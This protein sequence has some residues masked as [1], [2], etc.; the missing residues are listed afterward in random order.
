MQNG[1]PL[2]RQMGPRI[3]FRVCRRQLVSNPDS[4][5]RRLWKG[6]NPDRRR[7][8][9]H[10]SGTRRMSERCMSCFP[11]R[12]KEAIPMLRKEVVFTQLIQRIIYF[13][14]SSIA[15]ANAGPR[16][17]TAARRPGSSSAPEWKYA[18]FPLASIKSSTGMP[19]VFSPTPVY[20][21][22]SPS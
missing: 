7:F 19:V 9:G 4:S 10:T 3:R 13:S 15:D 8:A 16:C 1:V 12:R 17:L 14:A 11:F 6:Q 21:P 5:P 2:D 20:L 22:S 18:I